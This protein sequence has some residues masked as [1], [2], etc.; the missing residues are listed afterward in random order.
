MDLVTDQF[1][2]PDVPN[3]ITRFEDARLRGVIAQLLQAGAPLHGVPVT[4]D[5]VNDALHADIG[6][7]TDV[8]LSRHMITG[9]YVCAA[10]SACTASPRSGYNM[11]TAPWRRTRQRVQR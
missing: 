2:T 5:A 10:A 7:L 9:S 1:V 4:G 6:T 11:N 3:T 8:M